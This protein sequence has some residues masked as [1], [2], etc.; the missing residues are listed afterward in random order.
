MNELESRR[1]H[2][3][4]TK[5]AQ[6]IRM[7]LEHHYVDTRAGKQQAGHHSGRATTRDATRSIDL[8]SV[9][10]KALWN[11]NSYAGGGLSSVLGFLRFLLSS[12]LINDASM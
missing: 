8:H 1:V 12:A 11:H 6:E 7:L 10:R 9:G 3:I 5:V 2:R 4:A